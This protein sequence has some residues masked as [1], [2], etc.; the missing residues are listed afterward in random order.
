MRPPRELSCQGRTPTSQRG[1]S[2]CQSTRTARRIIH[3]EGPHRAATLVQ[4][5][6]NVAMTTVESTITRPACVLDRGDGAPPPSL[7][8]SAI[9]SGSAS[10]ARRG[11]QPPED[12]GHGG[13]E[14][15]DRKNWR[16]APEDA[17]GQ[18]VRERDERLGELVH[19][20]HGVKLDLGSGL[21]RAC[22]P[23]T[24]WRWTWRGSS[25]CADV[26]VGSDRSGRETIPVLTSDP[27]PRAGVR[28]SDHRPPF[29]RP[30]GGSGHQRP[31]FTPMTRQ[32][33]R[34]AAPEHRD[35]LFRAG[36]PSR[37]ATRYSSERQGGLRGSGRSPV[38]RHPHGG[39]AIADRRPGVVQLVQ[40]RSGVSWFA[41]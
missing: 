31:A 8:I 21:L 40:R 6:P 20:A 24:P 38:L 19:Q 15:G 39:P 11:S 10:T 4:E 25:Y 36:R 32:R 30:H 2:G 14:E 18:A 22:L 28:A 7:G 29:V 5:Q 9:N 34:H 27:T 26:R 33:R 23:S 16:V 17:G 12:L 41:G 3:G 1:R 37:A 13:A 35:A